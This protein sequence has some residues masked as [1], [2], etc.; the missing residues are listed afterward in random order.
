MKT[1]LLLIIGCFSVVCHG[2]VTL[3]E[4]GKSSYSI[5]IPEKA[6]QMEQ[7]AARELQTYLKKA[8]DAV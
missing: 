6:T 7:L 5:C 4:Q 3:A 2:A 8:T 1:I